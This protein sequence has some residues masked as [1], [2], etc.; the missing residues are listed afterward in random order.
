MKTTRT[1][2]LFAAALSIVL[3]SSASAAPASKRI[4]PSASNQKSVATKQVEHKVMKRVG[5]IG[6][7]YVCNQYRIG[8]SARH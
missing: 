3:A 8:K 1:I 7:G 6:K 2:S 4:G 5:P